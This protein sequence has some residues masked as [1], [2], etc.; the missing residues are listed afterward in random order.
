M[1]LKQWRAF[2]APIF[3]GRKIKEIFPQKQA[4][5]G[6]DYAPRLA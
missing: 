3:F 6:A 1:F 5:R 2:I 4:S